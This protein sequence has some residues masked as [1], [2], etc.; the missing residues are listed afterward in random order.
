MKYLPTGQQM[1]DA[2]LY[3]INN[4]GI[5]SMVLMERAA[6]KVVEIIEERYDFSKVL[7]L[8]GSGNN[9]GDGYAAARLLHLKGYDVE[10]CF[11]GNENSRSEENQK[12]KAIADY[13]QIPTVTSI[14]EKEYN[15]IIDAIFGTG[16]KR[17]I[18]GHYYDVILQANQKKAIKVAIDIP[19]GVHDSTGKIMGIAFEADITVAI[20]FIKRGLILHPGAQYTGKILVGDIGITEDALTR[21]EE[22]T[23]G[24]GIEDLK[25]K[26]PKRK[27]NSHKGSYGKVLMIV[28]SSGMS[29]AAYLSAKAAYAVG[30]GLVQ[31][32]TTEDNRVIL[33][34][35]LPEAIVKTYGK[36]DELELRELLSWADVVGIG[37]GLG[38]SETSVSIVKQTIS[39]AKC[40][41]IVDAD[42]LN[43]LSE[44][45]AYMNQEIIMT[46][47]MKEMSRLLHCTVSDLS[48]NR[49][50][51]LKRFVT[52]HNITCALKDARTLVQKKGEQIYLNLSGNAAMAKG[53]AGDVLTGIITGIAGQNIDCY[54]AACLGVYLH[55]LAGDYAK[56]KKGSY[57][58]LAS[59]IIEGIY[60]ILKEI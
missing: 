25:M 11:V 48:E 30:A 37:C 27:Q 46:P 8:C 40:P 29:G 20:A 31:I 58:V 43:I 35:L 57:S 50:E 26:Y 5:P 51:Y 23:V 32:Y 45:E 59:D 21:S 22:L 33:Q 7:V 44:N 52:E 3:T 6:L 18:E 53:G 14:K 16:L 15:V 9:G 19:S 39:E 12:Q 56:E 2:D 60:G 34:Q 13:Y 36:Y 28:G 38:K 41:C 1:R 10:I 24:Y 17:A 54:T 4:I 42:A 49:F 55:G 47:H